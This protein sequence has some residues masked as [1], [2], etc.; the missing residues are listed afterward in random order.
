MCV[1]CNLAAEH[2]SR[3]GFAGALRRITILAECVSLL[4]LITCPLPLSMLAFL[5]LKERNFLRGK[6]LDQLKYV[7]SVP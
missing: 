7:A 3:M 4:P 1:R 5:F 6:Y 2:D